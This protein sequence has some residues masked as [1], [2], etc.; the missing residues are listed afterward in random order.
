M[1]EELKRRVVVYKHV[2]VKVCARVYN[3]SETKRECERVFGV[4]MGN[5]APIY[6][7]PYVGVW[8]R[9]WI[10]S[11]TVMLSFFPFHI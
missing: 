11:L 6:L 7:R 5:S 1:R 3:K 9:T 10:E 2:C 4:R 8:R